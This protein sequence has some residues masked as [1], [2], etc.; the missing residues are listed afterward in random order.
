LIYR[1]NGQSISTIFSTS[2][3]YLKLHFIQNTKQIYYPPLLQIS[4]H[5]KIPKKSFLSYFCHSAGWEQ[6]IKENK[7]W[8]STKR[9]VN[10]PFV[11][12]RKLSYAFKISFGKPNKKMIKFITVTNNNNDLLTFNSK[13]ASNWIY[14]TLEWGTRVR[15][16]LYLIPYMFLLW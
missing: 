10:W 1:T 9:S 7:L 4:V 12:I 11:I 14:F 5:T 3:Q 13:N 8:H 16:P 2:V 6:M 15:H